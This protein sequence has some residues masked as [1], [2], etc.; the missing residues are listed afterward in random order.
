MKLSP[1]S[2]FTLSFISLYLSSCQ[3]IYDSIQLMKLF[4]LWI[5]D[6]SSSGQGLKEHVLKP[7]KKFST[8]QAASS[9]RTSS[10]DSSRGLGNE[11]I[12]SCPESGSPSSKSST[13]A[14]VRWH[15]GRTLAEDNVQGTP[16]QV[17][18]RFRTLVY[19]NISSTRRAL[20]AGILRRG[21]SSSSTE[22]LEAGCAIRPVIGA[23]EH[24]TA[25]AHILLLRALWPRQ[26][27][28][29]RRTEEAG[30]DPVL[31][32]SPSSTVPYVLLLIFLYTV[33]DQMERTLYQGHQELL[34]RTSS[35]SISSSTASPRLV[36]V[37]LNYCRRNARLPQW[38]TSLA[39][40]VICEFLLFL[41]SPVL[42]Q[43]R[44]RA[45]C[46]FL[47]P[48]SALP[49]T[50]L[51]DPCISPPVYGRQRN[52]SSSASMALATGTAHNTRAVKR[53]DSE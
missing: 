40:R 38:L 1:S 11:G 39:H 18:S 41:P 4:G 28:K 36:D 16:L 20:A 42:T 46:R 26:C 27:K 6:L 21:P 35:K 48:P 51:A 8:D 14:I 10:S 7:Q 31:L 15:C 50:L 47:S 9:T 37:A 25:V 19:I 34:R 33:D 24:A 45:G 12:I 29:Y 30:I 13:V 32:K 5:P 3:A 23:N 52:D 43:G 44:R 49:A 53:Y 2:L 22:A 17:L